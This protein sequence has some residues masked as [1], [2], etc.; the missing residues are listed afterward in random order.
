MARSFD[1]FQVQFFDKAFYRPD[2]FTTSQTAKVTTFNDKGKQLE[3]FELGVPNLDS[4]YD[5]IGKGESVNLDNCFIKG[6]SL[7]AC[8]RYLLKGKNEIIVINN[9]SAKYA[10]FASTYDTDLT[11]ATFKGDALAFSGTTFFGG[12]V[13]FNY[14][15]FNCSNVQLDELFIK[16][17]RFL[18]TQ[19]HTISENFSLKNTIFSEGHKDFQDTDFGNGQV[20][21]INTD[22]GKGDVSFVNARFNNSEANFKVTRFG[23]GKCDFRY[24]RFG[25]KTVVFE[26]ADF[27][28]GHIDF[29]NVDFGSGKT[30]FNRCV[31][32]EG[33]V[34]FDGAEVRDG[35]VSFIKSVFGANEVSFELFQAHESEV[36]FDR[37]VFPGNISFFNGIF[38]SLVLTSCQFNGTLNIHVEKAET[39]D[40]SGCIARDIVDFYSHGEPPK[41]GIINFSGFRLLGRFYVQ[42]DANNIKAAIYSQTNTNWAVKA[43]QFRI[44]KQNFSDLGRYDDE[45]LAYVELMRCRNRH[46]LETQKNNS[47]I[48]KIIA[49]PSYFFK[50][51]VFDWMGLYAT[52]PQ[53]VIVSIVV[54]ILFFSSLYTIFSLTGIGDVVASSDLATDPGLFFRSIYICIITFFTIGYGEF[55]PLGY[56]RVI[57]SA[58]G[59][60]GVFLMSYFTVAFVRKILR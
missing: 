22:F 57:S 29:R 36:I 38:K 49:Y 16:T 27:C 8:R 48:K 33:S 53:R 3:E 58:L 34:T 31:F 59:F 7:T 46:E 32:S 21:F 28:K 19:C 60:M 55:I 26:Q 25:N 37:V 17:D 40:L 10:F 35:K 2:G 51:L 9:F 5:S 15:N 50:L 54:I 1:T 18:M 13:N 52:S 6:F 14:S 30:S 39:I 24:A 47:G 42:W 20:S 41:V 43:D 45:D 4:I 11:Y 44:L 56:S 12:G 23:D